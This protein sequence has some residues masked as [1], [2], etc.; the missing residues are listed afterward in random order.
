MLCITQ[1]GA[2]VEELRNQL[3]VAPERDKRQRVKQQPLFGHEFKDI[4]PTANARKAV[5]QRRYLHGN[6]VWDKVQ[7]IMVH[8]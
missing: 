5:I 6:E 7:C 1:V 8:S 4:E 2:A 3:I